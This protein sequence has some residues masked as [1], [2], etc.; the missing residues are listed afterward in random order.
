MGKRKWDTLT[1]NQS[2][3]GNFDAYKAIFLPIFPLELVKKKTPPQVLKHCEGEKN[4]YILMPFI[5]RS[6][7]EYLYREELLFLRGTYRSPS[8][9]YPR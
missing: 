6:I 8:F 1:E 4:I 2:L 9:A 5:R 7:F 3:S